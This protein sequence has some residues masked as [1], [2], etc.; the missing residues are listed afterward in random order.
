MGA[1]DARTDA[2]ANGWLVNR[3]G[4]FSFGETA[5]EA[6]EE[7]RGMC[8]ALNAPIDAGATGS[9]VCWVFWVAA[10][11]RILPVG[12]GLTKRL[13][14]QEL[15]MLILADA[16]TC[17][18]FLSTYSG[19]IYDLCSEFYP[20]LSTEPWSD[21]ESSPSCSFGPSASASFF[22]PVV[23]PVFA[24]F[25]L[26]L[27]S[28]LL[29]VVLSLLKVFRKGIS[30]LRSF[31]KLTMYRRSVSSLLSWRLGLCSLVRILLNLILPKVRPKCS[32][33]SSSLR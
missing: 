25:F 24:L 11:E 20:M 9:I 2:E 10:D 1:L 29:C 18:A 8:G 13:N 5:L 6:G 27:V 22:E 12:G 23:G 7:D 30:S 14:A 16:A 32:I 26:D 31:N 4:W 15:S 3:S 28:V 17:L 21:T 19:T 33:L